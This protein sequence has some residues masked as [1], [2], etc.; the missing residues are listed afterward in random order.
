MMPQDLAQ[1]A[2]QGYAQQQAQLAALQRS[3][4]SGM[5]GMGGMPGGNSGMN[6]GMGTGMGTPTGM[7]RESKKKKASFD[8]TSSKKTP[9]P[10][11]I[12]SNALQPCPYRNST[13][14]I[15]YSMLSNT[16]ILPGQSKLRS[17]S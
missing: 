15:L 2:Q 14:C 3:N 8:F 5:G 1:L 9:L 7:P 16:S 11:P 10:F 17:Q 4:G 6:M 13:H 12:Y